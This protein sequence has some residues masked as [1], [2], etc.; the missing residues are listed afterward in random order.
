MGIT[1]FLPSTH[2]HQEKEKKKKKKKSQSTTAQQRAQ[3]KDLSSWEQLKSLLSCK[4]TAASQVYDPSK[5]NTKLISSS[6]GSSLCAIRDVVHGNT[7]VVHRADTSPGQSRR[8]ETVPLTGQTLSSSSS[9]SRGGMQLRRLSGCYE[10]HAVSVDSASRR[11]PRP[12]LC[13]CPDCGEVFTKLE[14]LEL[15]QATRHAVTELGVEDSGRNIVEIIFKSSWHRRRDLPACTI[16]RILKVHNTPRTLARFEDYRA[17]VKSRWALNPKKHPRCAAD[18]NELLRFLP[19]PLSCSFRSTSLC[20][21]A[22]CGVCGIIRHGFARGRSGVMTTASSGRAHEIG[23]TREIG[24]RRAMMVCRVI[25]GRVRETV[26]GEEE[27]AA[28]GVFDSVAIGGANLEE[29]FVENPKAILPCFVVIYR[30]VG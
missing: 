5:P 19:A 20:S 29:L 18:G 13:S 2:L 30:M 1:P 7:R 6:C 21:A 27:E 28:M 3:P 14:T 23:S 10:C 16:E 4:N 12:R 25:A 22:A 9:C 15:H 17:G 11:Y 8:H 26:D 24:T